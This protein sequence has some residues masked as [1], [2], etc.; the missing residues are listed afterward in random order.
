MSDKKEELICGEC[1]EPIREGQP[2]CIY[3]GEYCHLDCA[4]EAE[5]EAFFDR[6]LMD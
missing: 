6:D 3:D 4:A 5:D 1:E 2:S